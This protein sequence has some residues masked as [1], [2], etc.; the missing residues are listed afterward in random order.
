[1]EDLIAVDSPVRV[2]DAFVE[3]LDL[4]SLGFERVESSATGR[5]P[6]HPRDLLK[7]YVYGYLNQ[8]RSSRRLER[9][10]RRNIEVLW[11]LNRLQPDDKTIASF[12]KDNREALV[13]TCRAFVRFCREQA[14][15]GRELVAIDGTKFRA[16]G[17]KK[18]MYTPKRL[19]E[20][21][22]QI[23]RKVKG[24]LSSLDAADESEPASGMGS[25]DTASALAAL[26]A[27]RDT[28]QSLASELKASGESHQ[29]RTEPEAKLMSQRGGGYEVGYNV[30]TAVDAKHKL[31]ASHAVSNAGN[32]LNQLYP[33]A[34]AV[35]E[36]LGV[37][38]VTVVADVGYHN[39]EHGK[40]C[41]A[42]GVTAVVPAPKKANPHGEGFAQDAFFYTPGADDEG[43]GSYRCPAGQELTIYKTDRRNQVQY[44]NNP[45][46]CRGCPLKSDCT[47]S[48]WRSVSRRMDAGYS[49]AMSRR[50]LA[51]PELMRR[52]AALVEHPFGTL[53]RLMDS[54]QF[55]MRGL[56]G[57]RAEMALGV[58]AYN[59][60]RAMKLLGEQALC[61]RLAT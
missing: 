57:V 4:S 43:P 55:L 41:E 24:Y 61:E 1:L 33:M 13:G 44:Y 11:L 21:L 40:Q 48:E 22:A 36:A 6:Y 42:S 2:V 37:E 31:I 60:K 20:E 27:Q 28:L 46:A 34:R 35:K 26:E 51:E 19:R 7:L 15:F 52:R 17:S 3:S 30:Q 25:G 9:E 50:A 58:L 54:G 10:A 59:L 53:K 16:V 45:A 5:P 47:N 23:D 56:T 39:G 18:A 8:V 29:V 14:L 49:E 38:T 32:D 12:R